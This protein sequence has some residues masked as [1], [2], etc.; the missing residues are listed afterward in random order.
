VLRA[1]SYVQG[2]TGRLRI[3]VTGPT[4]GTQHDQLIVTGQASLGGF[5][6]IAR[7]PAYE[8]PLGET[9]DVVR[10][11][12]R[13]EAFDYLAG[14]AIAD[15]REFAAAYTPTT[16]ALEVVPTLAPAL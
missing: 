8:P 6:E 13:S 1:G 3:D 12:S 14:T 4:R 2:A 7:R 10:A 11:G 9:F 16:A 15:A 5:L